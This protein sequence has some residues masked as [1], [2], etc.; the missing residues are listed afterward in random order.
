MTSAG[1]LTNGI[2]INK[3]KL[4]ATRRQEVADMSRSLRDLGCAS[5]GRALAYYVQ[6]PGFNSQHHKK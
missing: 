6:I 2:N 1:F 5:A 3:Q 4:V